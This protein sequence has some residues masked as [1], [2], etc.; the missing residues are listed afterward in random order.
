MKLSSVLTRAVA[1]NCRHARALRH[2]DR[3]HRSVSEPIWLTLMR[4]EFEAL[5]SMTLLQGARCW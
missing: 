5:S 2:F 1:D 4:I 3:F